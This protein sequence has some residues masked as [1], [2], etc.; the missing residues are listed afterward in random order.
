MRSLII[1][2]IVIGFSAIIIFQSCLNDLNTLPLNDRILTSDKVYVSPQAYKGVLAKCY[3]SLVLTGQR[4]P[5]GSPDLVGMDEG[6]SSYTRAVLYL[7]ECTTDQLLFHSGAS[8]G[9]RDFLFMNWNSG[10]QITRFSY[11]RLFMTIGY[12]NEFLRESTDEKLR[13]RKLIEQLKDEIPFYR[14]EVRFI[15][16]YAYSMLCDLFGSVPFIDETMLPGIIPQQ[17]SREQIYTYAVSE[18]EEV[19]KLLKAPGTNEYGRVDQVAAWFLLSRIYLNASTY[20]GKQ[21]NEKA[22]QYAKKIIDSGK[23]PL[24]SDYRHIF[25]AGNQSCN[26]IIWRL[27]QDVENTKSF[28]GTNFLIKALS[29]GNMRPYNGM[30]EAWGNA[31]VKTQLVDKFEI[32]DQTFKTSDPWGDSKKDKRAQFYT[33]SHTKETWIAGSALRNDFTNGYAC[34]KYRNVTKD[35]KPLTPNGT[36][37][38]MIDYPMFRTAD[39]YL[40]AAE[41]ILRGASGS[42]TEAL[43]YINEIRD[44]AY[45]SGKYGTNPHGRITDAQLT[46][47]FILDERARELH[48][49]LIR[50]TDLIRYGKFTKGYN[51]DWKG[52]NGA[53]GNFMGKDVDDKYKLFPIPQEEFTVNPNLKQNP[54]FN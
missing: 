3:G 53:A 6:Y 40:M 14:A 39:A 45:L 5:S 18:A 2:K 7:Q 48:T 27:P 50:R 11:Y 24:E 42:R 36:T 49:E 37:Y 13:E 54:D 25:L 17:R 10:T 9:S 22:Y 1:L 46:L 8:Q 32:S 19:A 26:E 31:R 16:A 21:E 20:I 34:L 44:R 28:G 38:T 12:C 52:S 15:R 29:S 43:N 4:G 41:A 30:S 33:V 23:Y 35:R 47:D 51:W